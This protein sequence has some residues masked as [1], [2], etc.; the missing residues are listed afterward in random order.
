VDPF[1]EWTFPETAQLCI[2]NTWEKES[3]FVEG[4][5]ENFI[6]GEKN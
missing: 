2:E 6:G 4:M 3:L 1:Y 5:S